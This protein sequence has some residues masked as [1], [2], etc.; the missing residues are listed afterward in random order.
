MRRFWFAITFSLL[1]HFLLAFGLV[2]VPSSWLLTNPPREVTE[3]QLIERPSQKS[4]STN[5]VRQA[6]APEELIDEQSTENAR[7][8]S[9]QRQRVIQETRARKTGLTRNGHALPAN[10]WAKALA[11]QQQQDSDQAEKE[12]LPKSPDGYEP[13]PL[14]RGRRIAFEDAPS[15]VGEVLP[16]SISVG[17]FTALN[18]DRFKYYSFYAR[19]EELVRFRWER[20]LE[21]AINTFDRKYLTQV[22][23]NRRWITQVQFV[24]SADGHF[25]GANI[26]QESGIPRFDRVAVDSF[27]E[28]GFFPNPP[29]EMIGPDGYIHI[30]YSFNVRWAPSSMAHDD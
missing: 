22:V 3:I 1:V 29:K 25:R 11:R 6:Q 19:I 4:E 12:K 8:L 5:L 26:Q 27:R 20:G 14:P 17:D 9:E 28:A 24:L 30:D 15:T 18:T 13:I 7:F 2:E 21:D 23:G 10:S 16:D